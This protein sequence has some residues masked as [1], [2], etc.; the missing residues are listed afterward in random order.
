MIC[1]ALRRM[2]TLVVTYLIKVVLAA[3]MFDGD[4]YFVDIGQ[5]TIHSGGR[6]EFSLFDQFN[7]LLY[8]FA[9]WQYHNQVF[10]FS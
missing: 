5:K 8:R 9:V 1:L 3:E 6:R 4:R 10:G 2:S 7:G